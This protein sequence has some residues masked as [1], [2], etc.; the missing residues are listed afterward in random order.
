MIV[1]NAPSTA[2]QIGAGVEN[3]CDRRF[4]LLASMFLVLSFQ[5]MKKIDTESCCDIISRIRKGLAIT[6]SNADNLSRVSLVLKSPAPMF[7][8]AAAIFKNGGE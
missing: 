6:N 4:L 5:E 3:N 2:L 7:S 8:A 1:P